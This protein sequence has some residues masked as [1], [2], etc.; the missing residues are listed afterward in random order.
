MSFSHVYNRNRH[1]KKHAKVNTNTNKRMTTNITETQTN[2]RNLL[3]GSEL[4]RKK[5][6]QSNSVEDQTD[7][8]HYDQNTLLMK[9]PL[10][11]VARK[12]APKSANSNNKTNSASNANKPYRCHECYKSFTTDD[13]LLR[14]A[15]VHS[16]DEEVKPLACQICQKRFLNNSA[17]SCHLKVHRFTIFSLI[18]F[19]N[20]N[21]LKH[22][23]LFDST[24]KDQPRRYDCVICKQWFDSTQ[25]RK[26]HII[27]HA[28]PITGHYTCPN[29]SKVS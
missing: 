11:T 26:D 7:G 2:E 18:I 12:S 14:H 20:T 29:C 9:P 16:S 15:I 28:D 4:E 17:L 13:R 19:I 8:Q 3:F 22:L 5:E 6:N 21:V 24:P 27:S 10:L 23:S 1:V 25:I